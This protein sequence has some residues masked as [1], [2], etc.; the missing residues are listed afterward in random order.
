MGVVGLAVGAVLCIEVGVVLRDA[1]EELAGAGEG[2][3]TLLFAN[4]L[5]Q[6]FTSAKSI[7]AAR[8]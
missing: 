1:L 6:T 7:P 2:E 4:E 3:A 5:T 8:I